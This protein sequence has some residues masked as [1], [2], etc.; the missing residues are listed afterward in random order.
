MAVVGSVTEFV[1][2]HAHS[3]SDDASLDFNRSP[4]TMLLVQVN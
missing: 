1:T 4:L 2:V 3:R